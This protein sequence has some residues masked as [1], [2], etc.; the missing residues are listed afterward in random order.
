MNLQANPAGPRQ[1]FERADLVQI[2]VLSI[3]GLVGLVYGWRLFWFLT[4][5]A[6]IAF[7]YV[8]NSLLGYGYV[9]NP[10]PFQPVEGYTSFLWVFLLDVVWRVFGVAPPDSANVIS[11]LFAG[12]TLLCSIALSWHLLSH[13]RFRRH[14]LFFTFLLLV[15]ILTNR[16]FLAWTSSGL[17]TAMFNFLIALWLFYLLVV[18]PYS[19]SWL[20]GI[21]A[22]SALIYLTRPDG[23]LFVSVTVVLVGF[24]FYVQWRQGRIQRQGFFAWVPL[25]VVPFHL[26]WRWRTYGDWLPNTYYAKTVSA[27]DPLQS[28]VRYLLSFAIEYALWFAFILLLALCIGE[29]IQRR[30][31]I[32]RFFGYDIGLGQMVLQPAIPFRS[33]ETDKPS[34]RLSWILFVGMAMGIAGLLTGRTELGLILLAS[35]A[36]G[37]VLL[38]VLNL[39]LVR[40]IA[41]LT[42]FLHVSY[43]TLLVGGD[44][45]EFR[46]YS[47]LIPFLFLGFL[48]VLDKTGLALRQS[49]TLAI[50]F[51][52]FSWPIPWT[53][54]L[55]TH[56]ITSREDS[57][58][59]KASVSEAMAQRFGVLPGPMLGYLDL[60][61][62]LQ[63]WLIDR[64]IGLR[65]QEHKSFHEFLIDELPTRSV[66]QT[67]GQGEYPVLLAASVG[68]VSWVLPRVN[69]IDGLGL[70]DRVVARNP[71]IY[72]TN[73]MAHQ[74]MPPVGYLDCFSPDLLWQGTISEIPR[75]LELTATDIRECESGYA[76]IVQARQHDYDRIA[77]WLQKH[78]A[79]NQTIATTAVIGGGDLSNRNILVGEIGLKNW[80]HTIVYKLTESWPDFVISVPYPH[81]DTIVSLWWFQDAYEVVDDFGDLT[82]FRR[83]ESEK[84]FWNIPID[85]RYTGGLAIE[86]AA[87][88]TKDIQSVSNLDAWLHFNVSQGQAVDYQLTFFLIDTQTD[89]RTD[90]QSEWPFGD[91]LLFPTSAWLENSDVAVPLRLSVPDDLAAGSYRLGMF[92]YD[93]ATGQ[94]LTLA[95]APDVDYPEVQFGYF[96]LGDPPVPTRPAGLTERSVQ[97]R[98]E[99]GIGLASVGLPNHPLR[100]GDVL[101][102]YLTWRAYAET[103]R[104]LTV[105]LHVLNADGEIVAQNDRRP[106]DGRFPTAVW[107][108]DEELS[109]TMQVALPQ[110]ILPGDYSIRMGLYDQTGRL[111]F[112]SGDGD[113]ILLEKVLTIE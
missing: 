75:T 111:P 109:D 41:V 24:S 20:L 6:Y 95:N 86:Q 8:S 33:L 89:K 39:S 87:I 23:L 100:S 49:A 98:W 90:S 46:V 63:F 102:L 97:T 103:D 43:Y 16:T 68:V 47:H 81:W 44:H 11:L 55:A 62:R 28:G 112:A 38:S 51:I 71:D 60:Y 34:F 99:E 104:D 21:S 1:S 93:P 101:P 67:L 80:L 42:I 52:V 35:T 7:R 70:N 105:F 92:V 64:A 84:L 65:H 106:F 14:R 72:P 113:S 4:D 30:N 40:A 108:V 29:L 110:D 31:A 83:K 69:I 59:L 25:G 53:H 36:L 48:W 66:G 58:F 3:L 78:S 85:A 19:V 79:A 10:P 5:D 26:L 37:V 76:Q 9:W 32:P 77:E 88:A 54:W 94:G 57:I 18:R 27:I 17:E 45:F 15:W 56:N 61:D 12:L 96:R 82:L 13:S 74:R 22:S 73:W 107:R 2:G 91:Y 50:L